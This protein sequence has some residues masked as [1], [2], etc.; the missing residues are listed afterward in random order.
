MGR[1]IRMVPPNYVHPKYDN[2]YRGREDQPTA[3]FV[4]RGFAVSFESS[5]EGGMIAGKLAL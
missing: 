5:S 3:R 2:P 4:G 1:E